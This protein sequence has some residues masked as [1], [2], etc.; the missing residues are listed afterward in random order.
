[1]ATSAVIDTLGGIQ[2]ARENL[3]N[4]PEATVY[5]N[6]D[7]Q[8][9]ILTF[10]GFG[11]NSRYMTEAMLYRL[12]SMGTI[13][14]VN[15]AETNMEPGPREE[16][17]Y[18]TLDSHGLLG[19]PLGFYLRSSAGIFNAKI[20]RSLKERGL[21]ID[22]VAF[23]GSPS[24]EE[25][26]PEPQRSW[27]KLHPLRYSRAV[28]GLST[29]F[30]DDMLPPASRHAQSSSSEAI[31][32]YYNALLRVDSITLGEQAKDILNPQLEPGL[33]AGVARKLVF[34]EPPGGDPFI[35]T[36]R[37]IEGWSQICGEEVSVVVDGWRRSY[38]N[39]HAAG[40]LYPTGVASQFY[41]MTP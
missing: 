5:P 26:I 4:E 28:N 40:P 36:P 22:T 8:R 12:H 18:N 3:S 41:D 17:I 38:P 2:E 27:L 25:D 24:S 14:A 11:G 1:M 10:D 29:F 37:A 30:T 33:L 31:E 32:A 16:V 21:N 34:L 7:K 15:Y 35:N 20:L 39:S 19:S 9:A 6:P 23:D 13:V